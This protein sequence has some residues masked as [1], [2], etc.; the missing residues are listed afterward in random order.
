[1]KDDEM[2]EDEVVRLSSLTADKSTY[3]SVGDV[4]SAQEGFIRYSPHSPSSLLPPPHPHC[5]Q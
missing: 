3:V 1:M 4:I 2:M 5:M